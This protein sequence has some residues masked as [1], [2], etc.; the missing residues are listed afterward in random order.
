[1][2]RVG[3]RALPLREGELWTVT[4]PDDAARSEIAPY[5]ARQPTADSPTLDAARMSRRTRMSRT[6]KR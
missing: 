6:S 3:T 4:V 5:Q 2:R 1:M